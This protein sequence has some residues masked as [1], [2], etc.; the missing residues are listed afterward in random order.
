MT[1]FL[2]SHPH[3][4]QR[5][6]TLIEVFIAIGLMAVLVTLGAFGLR[7]YW[8]VQS[9]DSGTDEAVSQLRQLQERVVS[10]SHPLVY[11]ARFRKGSPDYAL[12]VYDPRAVAPTPMCTQDG[13]IRSFDRGSMSASI[14]VST[15]TTAV[16]D[17][18]EATACRAELSGVTAADVFV[19]FYARGSATAGT[20]RLEQTNLNRGENIV[21]T[22]LTGRVERT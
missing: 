1:T 10:E 3:S 22:G 14:Q 18:A 6:Y 20:I 13:Q 4:D 7:N 21:I 5:G 9:L 11:G 17:S 8:Y 19:F 15:S 16:P 12:V 2:P